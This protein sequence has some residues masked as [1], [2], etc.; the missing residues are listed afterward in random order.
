MAKGHLP[1]CK[2]RTS[3]H[4]KRAGVQPRPLSNVFHTASANP[5]D[6]GI[7]PQARKLPLAARI[8][9]ARQYIGAISSAAALL[10]NVARP[11]F[12][13][14]NSRSNGTNLG[15]NI[16]LGLPAAFRKIFPQFFTAYY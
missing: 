8:S 7:N 10:G 1:T 14:P 11:P 15:F 2:V 12:R 5:V 6:G 9:V 16:E 3:G 4:A 13:T